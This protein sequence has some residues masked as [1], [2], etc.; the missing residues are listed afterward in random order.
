MNIVRILSYLKKIELSKVESNQPCH[1]GLQDGF[2]FRPDKSNSRKLLKQSI[3]TSIKDIEKPK[4]IHRTTSE[5]S[6]FVAKN[7]DTKSPSY[8]CVNELKFFGF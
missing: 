2:W 4:K 8:L 7:K 3:I 5:F 6:K 1:A